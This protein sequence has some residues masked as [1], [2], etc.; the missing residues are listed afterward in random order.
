MF[1]FA[2]GI[3]SLGSLHVLYYAKTVLNFASS[4]IRSRSERDLR[5]RAHRHHE[6][7]RR[8]L[9]LRPAILKFIFTFAQILI[10]KISVPVGRQNEFNQFKT[11]F[12]L[13]FNTNRD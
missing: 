5:E 1:N 2:L 4:Q 12:T 9:T 8:Q 10:K 7:P 6:E 13:D 11:N 3:R